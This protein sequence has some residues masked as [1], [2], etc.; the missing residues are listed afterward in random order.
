MIDLKLYCP[1]VSHII[2]FITVVPTEKILEP[3]YTPNV[4]S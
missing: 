3:N 4:D 2:A 1:A